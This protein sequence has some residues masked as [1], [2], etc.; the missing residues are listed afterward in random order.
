M[1]TAKIV[2]GSYST[3]RDAKGDFRWLKKEVHIKLIAKPGLQLLQLKGY[4]PSGTKLEASTIKSKIQ[5]E[6]TKGNHRVLIP[7][8]TD[9]EQEVTIRFINN[10]SVDG[11]DRE[12]CFK[13]RY[14]EVK[15]TSKSSLQSKEID[16]VCGVGIPTGDIYTTYALGWLRMCIKKIGK[17][18]L[19]LSGVLIPPLTNKN[20]C[21]VT[22]NGKPLK[23]IAHGLENSD[24]EILGEVAFE[25]TLD[26]DDYKDEEGIRFSYGDAKGKS[27]ST[28]KHQDWYWPLNLDNEKI[29]DTTNMKR[30]GADDID[31]FIFSGATFVEKLNTIIPIENKKTMHVLD[32]GCGCGRLTRHLI[33]K[34]Y[35][36]ITGIDID[37]MNIEW[38]KANLPGAEFKQVSPDVPTDILSDSIDLIV[39]HSV[40]THLSEVDQ[41]LWLAELARLMK[42][43]GYAVITVME[44]YSRS[45]EK[46]EKKDYVEL[47]RKGFLDVGWQQDGVDAVRPGFYRRIFHTID[48]IIDNWS[49]YFKIEAILPGYSDH[50][51]AIVLRKEE[52]RG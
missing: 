22:A 28:E 2:E 29:P 16:M 52:I 31:W 51:T 49:A 7:V 5:I 34:G 45:I 27:L 3:E 11:D 20:E 14:L 30:I 48:Y 47:M 6:L 8:E 32:W 39:G 43:G 36:K 38:C 17:R 46:F 37:N 15:D 19:K 21:V 4:A 12:L 41:Y 18:K 35:G 9:E 26:I 33:N 24:Y 42:A 13:A 23:E 40:M 10:Y 44:S 1:N 50:Q 25:G